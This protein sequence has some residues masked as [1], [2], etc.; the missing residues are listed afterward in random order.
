MPREKQRTPEL[1]DRVLH[2]AVA[3][4]ADE[5]FAGFT[6]RKVAHGA[7]TSIPAVYELFGDKAGLVREILFE[8]FRRLHAQLKELDET[9]DPRADLGRLIDGFRAFV[10][11]NPVLAHVMFGRPFAD[12]DPDERDAAAQASLNSQF[13]RSVRRCVDAGV[14]AGDPIDIAHILLAFAQGLLAQET[15]GW[16]GSTEESKDRRW[17]L[18]FDAVLAGLQPVPVS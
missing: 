8:G 4:L 6:T 2:A 17:T 1:R 15:A 16:L 12:F 9:G 5:G 3:M 7:S 13:V 11:A 14:I 10:R 18:A